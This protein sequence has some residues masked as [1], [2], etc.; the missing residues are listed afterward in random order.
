L[1]MAHLE[2]DAR[3]GDDD[4]L[5]DLALG[6]GAVREDVEDVEGHGGEPERLEDPDA[7]GVDR[8]RRRDNLVDER[9][10]ALFLATS[11]RRGLLSSL[12]GVMVV[13]C[14]GMDPR[15]H[16]RQNQS[17]ESGFLWSSWSKVSTSPIDWWVLSRTASWTNFEQKVPWQLRSNPRE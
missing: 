13:L 1:E 3:R 2:R 6:E 14:H 16:V 12:A 15:N 5:A 4:P 10:H 17:G 8:A 9:F 7:R 11:F